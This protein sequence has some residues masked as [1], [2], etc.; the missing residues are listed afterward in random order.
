VHYTQFSDFRYHNHKQM[1]EAK[2]ITR[3]QV[4]EHHT[5]KDCWIVL[6]GNVYNVS[7]YLDEHPGG[8]EI[9]SDLAGQDATEEFED[10]G[11]SEDARAILKKYLV[12][13]VEGGAMSASSSAAKSGAAGG[14]NI[15]VILVVLLLVGGALFV[16]LK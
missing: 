13:E 6:H 16:A 9:I 15:L 3:V 4:S 11:H 10:T 7:K 1:T 8:P 12:G 2:T 14:P 5:D